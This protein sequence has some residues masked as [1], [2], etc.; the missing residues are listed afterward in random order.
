[1]R[2]LKEIIKKI[3]ELKKLNKED[4]YPAIAEFMIGVSGII[5]DQETQV[6]NPIAKLMLESIRLRL[7]SKP[8]NPRKKQPPPEYEEF[9]KYAH[10]KSDKVDPVLLKRK[11]ESWKVNGWKTGHNRP[12]KNWRTTL[13]NTLQYLESDEKIKK[14]YDRTEALRRAET[15][16]GSTKG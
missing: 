15:L 10:E 4:A 2:E 11:Y 1:M 13:L 14:P 6:E 9:A 8:R 16:F 5:N 12:I 7:E 3:D